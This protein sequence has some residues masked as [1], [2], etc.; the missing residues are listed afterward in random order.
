MASGCPVLTANRYGTAEIAGDAALLVD[1]E[2]VDE[3]ADGMRRIATDEELRRRLVER[4][5]R[6]AR[7]F[8]WE[9]CARETLRVL[10]GAA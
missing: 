10:E 7:E 3:I 1:P 4:G 8:S 5:R 6:R 2:S 9:T